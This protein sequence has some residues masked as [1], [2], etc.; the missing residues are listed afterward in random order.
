MIAG[1]DL[2]LLERQVADA[3]DMIVGA[4]DKPE[5]LPPQSKH[6]AR[7]HKGSSPV[8]PASIW[9]AQNGSIDRSITAEHFWCLLQF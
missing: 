4:R 6:T 3:G 1:I 2:G 8:P 5:D 9:F 7:P